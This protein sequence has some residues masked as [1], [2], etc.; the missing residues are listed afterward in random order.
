VT[1]GMTTAASTGMIRAG[2][3]GMTTA[4][5]AAINVIAKAYCNGD[6]IVSYHPAN[7]A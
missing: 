5:I 4:T 1:E 3:I 6:M 7:G 2:D